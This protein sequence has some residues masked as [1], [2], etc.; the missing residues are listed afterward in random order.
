MDYEIEDLEDNEQSDEEKKLEILEYLNR[1]CWLADVIRKDSMD[2]QTVHEHDYPA[3]FVEDNPYFDYPDAALLNEM[4]NDDL[5]S[6]HISSWRDGFI[7][8]P[9]Y[10]LRH[11]R[12]T[13][14]GRRLIVEQERN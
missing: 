8:N 6:V 3:F 14:K 10:N 5:L 2:T 4:I 7:E 13:A 9:H 1:G 11:F 12:L